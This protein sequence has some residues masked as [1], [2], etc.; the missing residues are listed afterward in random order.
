[1]FGGLLSRGVLS[2][3]RHGVSLRC[4]A[5]PAGKRL[6]GKA[7]ERDQRCRHRSFFVSTR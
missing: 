2:G 3:G 7:W 4:P 5:Q 6:R 1:L